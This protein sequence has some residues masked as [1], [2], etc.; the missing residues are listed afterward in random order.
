LANRNLL[1][2]TGKALLGLLD[3]LRGRLIEV[4][5]GD[6][7]HRGE[8]I[9]V[10]D[11]RDLATR[12][13]LVLRAESGQISLVDLVD[14]HRLDVL[15]P[16][17]REDLAFL[18]DRSRAATAG[19]HCDLTVQIRGQ[20][21][22]VQVGYIVAAPVWRVSY[23]LIRDGDTLALAAMGIIHNPVDEDLADVEVTLTTGQP[24]SF[25]IDLYHPRHVQRAV[26]AEQRRLASPRAEYVR[27]RDGPREVHAML[28]GPPASGSAYDAYDDAADDVQTGTTGEYFEY[29]LGTPVSLNRGGAAMV[30]LAVANIDAVRRELV[31]RS[32]FDAAP[33]IML[34][35]ANAT[36]L[37]LEE[38]PA[39]IYEQDGYAGEAMLPFTARGADVRLTFAKDLAVHCSS[40]YTSDTVTARVRLAADA[41]IEEQRRERRHVLR[42]ENDHD[43][44]VDVIFEIPRRAGH[45]VVGEG[46]VGP[47]GLAEEGDGGAWHRFPVTVP[48]HQVTEAVVLETWPVYTEIAYDELSPGRLEEWLAGRSLDAAAIDALSDVLTQSGQ[49]TRLDTRREQV[50]ADRTEV[51]EAQRHITEQLRV[52]GTDGA[53]GELRARQ[54]GELAALQDRVAALDAD[55]RRLRD[56]AN[57]AREAASAELQR[58]IG[59]T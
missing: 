4:H 39:V 3:G 22:D 1:F 51:H 59:E 16:S 49:A 15:E 34:A 31:W 29:R 46:I 14:A 12:R 2:K 40:T 53:E 32:G 54:V 45:T 7:R 24:I 57:A 17:S 27:G 52:L 11:S 41:V 38:G 18:I 33:E 48:G 8:V 30:P 47:G 6:R 55:V 10:D 25:D 21:D 23:R 5:C 43:E 42:A 58:V 20:A 35:F 56:Q 50:E 9:G 37:V 36:G 19:E 28:A 13:Q 26:V 44:P